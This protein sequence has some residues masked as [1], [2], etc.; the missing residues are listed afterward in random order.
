[1]IS[2]AANFRIVDGAGRIHHQNLTSAQCDAFMSI[3]IGDGRYV[4]LRSE[5]MTAAPTPQAAQGV[6]HIVA[7]QRA[8]E[9]LDIEP[10]KER[11]ALRQA[12]EARK[13]AAQRL[14]AARDAVE[15]ARSFRDA[16]MAEYA[17]LEAAHDV[18]IQASADSLAEAFKAGGSVIAH[19]LIDRGALVDG[20]TRLT[21]AAAALHQLSV[22]REAAEAVD[23]AVEARV[24]LAIV[25]IKRAYVETLT[26]RLETVRDEFLQLVTMIDGA[27]L[28]DCPVTQRA[29]RAFSAD[30]SGLVTGAATVKRWHDF[31]AA[32][33]EDSNAEFG[34][35]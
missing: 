9:Q 31:G 24:R 12:I 27:R 6:P 18:E 23:K 26:D 14:A 35:I 17:A 28:S 1:M 30:L 13:D 25:A 21:T 5:P 10:G 4:G 15:R 22:E 20:E 32:L 8:A 34:E 29:R 33:A 2:G 3:M 19:R 7:E 11:D 16:R